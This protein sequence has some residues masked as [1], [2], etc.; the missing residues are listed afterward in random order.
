MTFAAYWTI[1]LVVWTIAIVETWVRKGW[2]H[3]K[4]LHAP[5][6]IWFTD[7][8]ASTLLWPIIVLGYALGAA[9]A[10]FTPKD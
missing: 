9:R 1:G 10:I 8:I 4:T 3:V 6:W 7:M 5:G 2:E